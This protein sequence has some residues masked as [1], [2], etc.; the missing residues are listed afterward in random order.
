MHELLRITIFGSGYPNQSESEIAEI[1]ADPE[2]ENVWPGIRRVVHG[3]THMIDTILSVLG[4][5]SLIQTLDIYDHATLRA[6][7]DALAPAREAL[8]GIFAV[9]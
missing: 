2:L 8:D 3:V 1:L 7:A 6:R 4:P 9:P 5:T